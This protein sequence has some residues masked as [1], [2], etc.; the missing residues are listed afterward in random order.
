ME[1]IEVSKMMNEKEIRKLIK[2]IERR[3]AQ[4]PVAAHKEG[5]LCLDVRHAMYGT[6]VSVLLSVL[7]EGNYL[8]EYKR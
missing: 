2:A 6:I 3:N 5:R 4:C 1:A 7:G 8:D